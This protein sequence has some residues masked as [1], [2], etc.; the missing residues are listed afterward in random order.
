M[1]YSIDRVDWL[2]NMIACAYLVIAFQVPLYVR[3]FG[4]QDGTY[5]T[6]TYILVLNECFRPY[7]A[8]Y[9]FS[10]PPGSAMPALRAVS[11]QMAHTRSLYWDRYI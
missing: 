10:Y 7:L 3:H 2:G 5:L 9:A 4:V 1:G 8:A 11:L 6:C